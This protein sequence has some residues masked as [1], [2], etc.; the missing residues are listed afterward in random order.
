[1]FEYVHPQTAAIPDDHRLH[2]YEHGEPP[3]ATHVWLMGYSAELPA[4]YRQFGFSV[5]PSGPIPAGVGED[6]EA[7]ATTFSIGHLA[8]QVAGLSGFDIVRKGGLQPSIREIWPDGGE[9]FICPA[10]PVLNTGELV[11]VQESF[12]NT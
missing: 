8:C 10:G 7:Y 2:L 3:K 11:A 4:T 9:S 12:S 1:M 5:N 6:V